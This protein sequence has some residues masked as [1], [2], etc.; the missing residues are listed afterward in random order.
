VQGIRRSNAGFHREQTNGQSK[1]SRISGFLCRGR[2]EK[3]RTLEGRG[4][5]LGQ[6]GVTKK[7]DLQADWA[8]KVGFGDNVGAETGL[9]RGSEE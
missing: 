5:D 6:D 7:V 4:G 1:R 9:I 3:G 2:G 8:R